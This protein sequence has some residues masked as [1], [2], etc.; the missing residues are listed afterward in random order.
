MQGCFIFRCDIIFGH[1]IPRFLAQPLQH[2]PEEVGLHRG[3][4]T[5]ALLLGVEHHVLPPD[6][7]LAVDLLPRL[8]IEILLKMALKAAEIWGT[9]GKKWFAWRLQPSVIIRSG[10]AV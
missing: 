3:T 8:D 5:G 9:C 2:F 4:P 7:A 10:I 1:P 6:L